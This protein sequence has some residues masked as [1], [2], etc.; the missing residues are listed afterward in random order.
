MKIIF[1]LSMCLFVLQTY[2]A[3]PTY[4][5]FTSDNSEG[6]EIGVDHLYYPEHHNADVF[7]YP[8]RFF[9]IMNFRYKTF[10]DFAYVNYVDDPNEVKVIEQPRSFLSTVKCIDLDEELPR[11]DKPQL[12]KLINELETCEEL[13]FIDR[14]YCTAS[15][16]L[17]I[18]VKRD[19]PF[20]SVYITGDN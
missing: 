12:K 7:R 1:Y 18:P 20:D 2:S 17:L 13:Y 10:A 8:V 15:T 9:S 14:N 19:G 6:V 4:V 11:L 16:V 5:I 3:E